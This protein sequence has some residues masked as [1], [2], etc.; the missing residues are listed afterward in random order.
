MIPWG[1]RLSHPP[2]AAA[3]AK[4][5]ALAAEG[6]E[7]FGVAALAAHAQKSML[8]WS[9]NHSYVA[10]ND[11]RALHEDRIS[12][13]RHDPLR[14][15]HDLAIVLLSENG[16]A[17]LTTRRVVIDGQCVGGHAYIMRLEPCKSVAG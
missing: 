12:H 5:A 11:D 16:L 7:F 8:E 14:I 17:T 6:H 15:V 2:A 3:R 4:G 9:S 1:G 13:D 10:A